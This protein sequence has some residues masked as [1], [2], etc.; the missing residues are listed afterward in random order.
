MI[1][2][3]RM[4]ILRGWEAWFDTNTTL[5][6]L[7]ITKKLVG[8]RNP[9]CENLEQWNWDPGCENLKQGNLEKLS[10]YSFL[11]LTKINLATVVF[12]EDWSDVL[13]KGENVDDIFQRFFRGTDKENRGRW[14]GRSLEA[15]K[16]L[17]PWSWR[18]GHLHVLI[19][20]FTHR[21]IVE[22]LPMNLRIVVITILLDSGRVCGVHCIDGM[23][24][25]VWCL[26][27][28]R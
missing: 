14:E 1:Q 16:E 11:K 9:G 2:L 5:P 19:R 18:E 17:A 8:T 24:E 20:I 26:K 10:F 25:Q 6:R 28:I 12:F 15:Y 3:Q 23:T 22:W 21:L 27:K 4:T 13:I 7:L